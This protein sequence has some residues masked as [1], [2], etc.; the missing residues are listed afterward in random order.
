[1]WEDL[2]AELI[3]LISYAGSIKEISFTGLVNNYGRDEMGVI[4]SGR[5]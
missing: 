2:D 3:H 5:R 4:K 1:M